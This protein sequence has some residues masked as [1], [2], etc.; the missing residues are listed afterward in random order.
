[1]TQIVLDEAGG[2]ERL[3]ARQEPVPGPGPGEVLVRMEAAGVAF[4]D[5]TTRQGRNPGPLPRVLGFDVVGRVAALGSGVTGLEPGQRVAALLGTGGY[6]THVLV[7][8]ERAVPVPAEIDA[9]EIDALVV[10]YVTAWQMLHRVAQVRRGQSIL[11]VGAAGGVGSA[12]GQ[13][14]RLE[15]IEVYGTASAG[16]REA[17][18]AA[19][20]HWIADVTDVPAKVDAVFDP[21]GGP[22]L[23]NSRRVTRAGGVVVAYGF[24]FTVA[25]RHSTYGGLARTGAALVAAKVA[26]GPRVRVYRVE[27]SARK[28]PAAYREDMTR[29]VNLLAEGRIQ[30]AV[31]TLPLTAAAEAHRRLEARQVIGKLVLVPGDARVSTPAGPGRYV[32]LGSSFAAGPGIEPRATD[33][34]AKARQ[35]RRNYPHL[36]AQQRGLDLTDVTSSAATVENILRSTQLGQPPQITAVT[37][38][39]ELVTVTVGGNDIGYV[40]SLVAAALPAWATRLP[41]LGARLRRAM[42]PA[43]ASDR[44]DRTAASISEVFTEIRRRA[45]HARIICVDYLTILPP[46]FRHGLPFAEDRYQALIDLAADLRTAIARACTAQNV[47]IIEAS[48]HSISHHA[49]SDE[50]WTTGWIPPRPR[51]HAAFHPTADGMAAVAD[52]ITARLTTAQ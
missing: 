14:A 5:V 15:G 9:A 37:A 39:T 17:V 13:L 42:A 27:D 38:G 22:S 44:L 23:R 3:I 43:Q 31:T 19:G 20:G 47:D 1:M 45:P 12:I 49:F 8:A 48:E 2:P 10:N 26:P 32:A 40:P 41:L 28:H 18:E 6:S 50:P 4:N 16:R 33:R 35:S 21:V 30:P 51:G 34:P 52:L 46:T 24:S 29:L 11:V 25:A 36:L 7:D